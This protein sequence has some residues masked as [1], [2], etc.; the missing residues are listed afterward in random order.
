M[1]KMEHE[2]NS[3][4]L[5]SKCFKT[6]GKR[7]NMIEILKMQN[8]FTKVQNDNIKITIRGNFLLTFFKYLPL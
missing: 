7:G 4:Y 2:E 5:A 6:E 8:G 3:K 1:G